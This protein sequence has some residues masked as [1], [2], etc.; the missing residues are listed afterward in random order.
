M[1]GW[2]EKAAALFAEIEAATSTNEARHIFLDAMPPGKRGR[3][4]NL[5]TVALERA[6]REDHIPSEL[7]P[8]KR[9]RADLL[10][11]FH[12]GEDSDGAPGIARKVRRMEAKG[13]QTPA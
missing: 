1:S 2:A 3:P 10:Y 4:K 9:K 8:S 5:S 13:R 6:L 12:Y 7:A 11:T